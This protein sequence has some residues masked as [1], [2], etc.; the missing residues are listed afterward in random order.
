MQKKLICPEKAGL[1]N[2]IIC[3]APDWKRN[4]QPK[5]INKSDKESK[6]ELLMDRLKNI[7]LPRNTKPNTIKIIPKHKDSKVRPNDLTNK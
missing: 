5:Q 7:I 2:P 4:Q 1:V 3:L 6:K